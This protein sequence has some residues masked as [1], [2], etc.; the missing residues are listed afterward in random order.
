[1]VVLC[2][3][4]NE[5]IDE[6]GDTSWGSGPGKHH[7]DFT[8]RPAEPRGEERVKT[9]ATEDPLPQEPRSEK[10][11]RQNH[12]HENLLLQVHL[13]KERTRQIRGREDTSTKKGS[14]LL[15]TEDSLGLTT[16]TECC[17]VT[18]C[19]TVRNNGSQD[20]RQLVSIPAG[21]HNYTRQTMRDQK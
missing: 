18:E 12:C 2:A 6:S 16:A 1:M 14:K 20:H 10:G 8:G 19:A 4:H 21:T 17:S 7:A 5:P 3:A 13:Y 11:S 15:R 9:A